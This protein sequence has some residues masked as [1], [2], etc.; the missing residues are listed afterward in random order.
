MEC[1]ALPALKIQNDDNKCYYCR[2]KA[3]PQHRFSPCE[4]DRA[5]VIRP[6]SAV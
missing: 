3:F 6:A 1:G 4:A 5:L 2:C